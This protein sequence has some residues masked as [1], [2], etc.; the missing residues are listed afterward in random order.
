M[1]VSDL[2]FRSVKSPARSI[3]GSSACFGDVIC[4]LV[5]WTQSRNWASISDSTAE[6]GFSPTAQLCIYV[7]QEKTTLLLKTFRLLSLTVHWLHLRFFFNPFS[8]L[9]RWF[10]FF[11][12][13]LSLNCVAPK[14]CILGM[15]K[16]GYIKLDSRFNI[17]IF[18]NFPQNALPSLD[19]I[20]GN[21]Q[22]VHF[23]SIQCGYQLEGR[24]QRKGQ[25]EGKRKDKGREE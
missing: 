11:F 13:F 8:I 5:S 2:A 3:K 9:C 1:V 7:W 20:L 16:M 4:H 17:C 21:S 10:L 23:V 12:F 15:D 6:A 22:K 24:R 25:K 14:Y 18:H 19:T